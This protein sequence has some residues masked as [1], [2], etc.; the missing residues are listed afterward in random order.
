MTIDELILKSKEW[1]KGFALTGDPLKKMKVYYRHK[2]IAKV[3]IDEADCSI[4]NHEV[5][6]PFAPW[7]EFHDVVQDVAL[8][9]A[10]P[11]SNR[12]KREYEVSQLLK[13]L[14]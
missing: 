13:K 9:G 12:G 10:T 1:P 14:A 7:R 6:C 4:V 8:F 5:D 11:L 3:N 2:V